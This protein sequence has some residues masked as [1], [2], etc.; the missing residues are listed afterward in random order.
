MFEICRNY[1]CAYKREKDL[2]VLFMIELIVL[3]I[4]ENENLI[5]TKDFNL[6]SDFIHMIGNV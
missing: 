6:I 5:L 1:T 4:S 2:I 3:F